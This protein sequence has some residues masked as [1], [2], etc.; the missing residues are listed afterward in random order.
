MWDLVGVGV[1][2]F[3]QDSL[4]EG[5]VEGS[6]KLGLYS[7]IPKGGSQSLLKNFRTIS[8]MPNLHKITAKTLANR[9]QP[10]LPRIIQ[11]TQTAFVKDRCILDN[12][13]LLASEA[14]DWA[15]E[16]KQDLVIILLDFE[17]A[18][19][20]VKWTFLEAAMSKMGF[21]DTWIRWTSSLYRVAESAILVNGQKTKRISIQRS[22][23]QG[24]PLAPFLYL[25]FAGSDLYGQR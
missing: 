15:C 23:R 18:Y 7:L 8:V 1:T 19:D 11:P 25:F 10:L 6:L 9:I 2:E 4:A 17:K 24:C 20:R 12:I 5:Q 14:I 3:F 13:V 21:A 22:V 16:S